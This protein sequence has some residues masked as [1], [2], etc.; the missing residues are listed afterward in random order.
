MTLLIM[1]ALS[2][3]ILEIPQISI[4]I[5]FGKLCIPSTGLLLVLFLMYMHADYKIAFC[6]FLWAFP[7]LV[8]SQYLATAPGMFELKI[9]D[10][11]SMCLFDWA[12]T[13]HIIGWV[14][15]FYG[16]FACEG[17]SPALMTNIFYALLAPFFATFEAMNYLAGY[18]EGPAMD[19]IRKAINEDIAEY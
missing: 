12:L 16:H 13:L 6:Y 11:F 15:Q 8:I 17:R 10:N 2:W 1:G 4:L 5:P 14:A 7:Q 19:E 9:T 18:K 3:T